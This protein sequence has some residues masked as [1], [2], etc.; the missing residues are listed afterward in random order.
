MAGCGASP[1]CSKVVR[2]CKALRL[3]ECVQMYMYSPSFR[4]EMAINTSERDG[5]SSQIYADCRGTNALLLWLDLAP[6][7]CGG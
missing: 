1:D 6:A 5:R 4:R 7:F 3:E 2:C